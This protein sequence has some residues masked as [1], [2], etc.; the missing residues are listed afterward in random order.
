MTN[1]W[2]TLHGGCTAS[3]V[4]MLTTTAILMHDQNKQEHPGVSV[5]LKV[6]YTSAAKLGET[7]VLDAIVEKFGRSLAFT[8]A[9]LRRLIAIAQHIKAFPKPPSDK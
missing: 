3:L 9:D 1:S 6:S 7:V 4:D 8:R 5:D 2:D